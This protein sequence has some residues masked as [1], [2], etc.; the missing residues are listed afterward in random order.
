MIDNI[1]NDIIEYFD[2]LK[3]EF[4][5]FAAFHTDKIPLE[6][7]MAKL[8]R[9]NINSNP[10]CLCVKSCDDAWEHCI[11]RQPKVYSKCSEGAFFGT[12][13]AGMGEYVFPIT[14]NGEVL[15]FI[16]VSGYCFD[17]YKAKRAMRYVSSEYAIEHDMLVSAYK[18]NILPP[19][20]D[21]SKLKVRISALC[22][23]FVLLN[24]ELNTI[25][26]R[27]AQR[28]SSGSFILNQAAV[29]L[30]RSYSQNIH[31]S[32][33]AA[34]CNCSVSYISHMFKK[35]M[36]MSVYDYINRLRINDAKVLLSETDFSIRQISEMVGYSSPNY[37]SEVFKSITGLS[38]RDYK[39]RQKMLSRQ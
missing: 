8:A 27:S 17:E 2:Y 11:K 3:D 23:M 22:N 4:G 18:N 39:N 38:P 28:N 7:Y 9:Y 13:Y 30:N 1:I 10:Y 33:I 32:D 15:G 36:G 19:V 25:Y 14:D 6:N 31:V 37:M 35:N 16:D 34:H 20:D 24:R 21:Y 12:C 29:F 5:Y 26:S